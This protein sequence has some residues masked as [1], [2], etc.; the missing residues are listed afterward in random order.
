MNDLLNQYDDMLDDCHPLIEICGHKYE[1]S[2]VLKRTDP[3]CYKIG[4]QDWADSML[5]EG[6]I[7]QEQLDNGGH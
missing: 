7:T 1:P 6:L 2:T 5:A 3:I 4:F